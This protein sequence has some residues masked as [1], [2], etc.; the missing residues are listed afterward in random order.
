VL[1]PDGK[2]RAEIHL[3]DNGHNNACNTVSKTLLLRHFNYLGYVI[4]TTTKHRYPSGFRR[5]VQGANIGWPGPAAIH[6]LTAGG[7]RY[8]IAFAIG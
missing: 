6:E 4:A 1:R 7:C 8:T 2:L 3:K 5:S